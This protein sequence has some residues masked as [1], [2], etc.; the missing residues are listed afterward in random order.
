MVDKGPIFLAGVDRSGIGFLGELLEAHPNIAMSR[1]TNFWS[2]YLNRF[3]DLSHPQN[4]ERCLAEMMRNSRIQRLQPQPDRLRR[5]FSQGEPTYAR[6]FA[7]LQVHNMERLGKSRWGDKSLGAEGY[8]D[9][10]MTAYPKAK[11]IHIIRDPRDRYASQFSH[12]GVGKGQ[13]GAGVALWLWSVRLAERN[14]RKYGERYQI[15]QYETLV[16]EPESLLHD[17]CDFIGETY[18]PDVLMLNR[19]NDD[20]SEPNLAGGSRAIWTTS[21]GRFRTDLS[22]REVAFLQLCSHREMVRYGYQL[23]SISFS[24]PAK[25][26]FYLIDCPINLARLFLWQPWAGV[27]EMLGKTP[28]ARRL[29]HNSL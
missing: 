14:K 7:L 19:D 11:M 24:G 2:Y 12:R 23:D 1:R 13:L 28:S 20:S 5:E 3:G 9:I 15:I 25:L 22:E 26:F 27:K 8:A 29:V 6:L 4:F 10:V 21:I 18:S 16:C 17:L